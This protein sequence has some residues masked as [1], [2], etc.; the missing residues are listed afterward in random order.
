MFFLRVL[1]GLCLLSAIGCA[2]NPQ[3]ELPPIT[4]VASVDLERFSGRWYV[5]ANIPTF[6]EKKAWN[7]TEDYALIDAT[8]IDTTFAYNKGAFDGPRKTWTPVATVRAGTGNAVWDMQFVWPFK[9][10]YRVIWLDADY[11]VTMIGRS[12]RDYVW[13]MARQPE[14][15]AALRERLEAFLVA[16]GY[17]LAKLRNVPQ[18][19]EPRPIK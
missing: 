1:A 6:L 13:I 9:A 4:T 15:D 2:S 16:E 5:I 19:G 11:S 7:A 8:T 3:A 10:E 14:I 18:D 17:S 12:K